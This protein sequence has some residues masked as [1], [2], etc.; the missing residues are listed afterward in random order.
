MVIERD[1]YMVEE[2]PDGPSGLHALAVASQPFDLVL[3][4]LSMPGMDGWETLEALRA[5]G[6]DVPVILISGFNVADDERIEKGGAQAFL[7][8][9]FYGRQLLDAMEGV[10]ALGG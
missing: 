10:L 1:R 2:A 9:P 5:A 6:N 3:L 4:D 8:K 7:P